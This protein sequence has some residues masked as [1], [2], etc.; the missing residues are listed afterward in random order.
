VAEEDP[1]TGLTNRRGL[2][3]R[4]E[5]ELQ[6]LHHDG[7]QF[8]LVALDIDYFKQV[9]DSFGHLHG[10]RL[11]VE[12]ATAWCAEL[13]DGALLSRYGGDEFI[14]ILPDT[15]LGRAA[16]ITDRLRA[17]AAEGV[18]ISAGVAAWQY[19]DSGSMLLNRA[20]VALYDAK[21]C[22]RDRTVAYGDPGREA[23]EL[24]AAIAKGEM[25]VLLQPVVRLPDGE[26]IGFEALVR[27]E[28]PGRGLVGSLDFVPQAERTG[29]I[30]SLGAWMLEQSC[31][32]AM[33][34]PGPR[35]S[36]GV[37]VSV[38]ELRRADYASTVGQLLERWQMPGELLIVEVTESVFEDDD[39]QVTQSLHDLRAL[40]ALV[41]IDDFGAGYSSLRRIEHLP[42]DLIKV[43]GALVCSIREDH[44]PAILRA[45]VIMAESLGVNLVAEHV[46]TEYQAAVLH[47]LGY[48]LA[49]GYLFGRPAEPEQAALAPAVPIAPL[50]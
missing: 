26:P 15:P 5:A 31:R 45:I 2:E 43:D 44:D 47:Q 3:R 34:L 10:D 20:D 23:S 33:S 9:N 24:E 28:R 38:H 11:L 40:G 41:A 35:R 36:I 27:W 8:A 18:T 16:D 48:Q 17:V 4:L 25:R 29:A 1:L 22:G 37:N 14:L 42:I 39:P 50:S 32:L 7:G 46:E 30:H 12:C 19:G 49:Q 21:S 13:P 6:R